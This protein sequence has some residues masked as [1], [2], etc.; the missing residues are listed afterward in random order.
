MR[1]N[2]MSTSSGDLNGNFS[3]VSG[4]GRDMPMFISM[5]APENT[6]NDFRVIVNYDIPLL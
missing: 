6:M 1:M 4:S 2:L 3:K 5:K